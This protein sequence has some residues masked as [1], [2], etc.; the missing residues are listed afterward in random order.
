MT[1][2]R[3][4]HREAIDEDKAFIL[5]LLRTRLPHYNLHQK[6]LPSSNDAPQFR[7]LETEEMDILAVW[8]VEI[9][10]QKVGAWHMQFD[11]H[12]EFLRIFWLS[13][14][15][16]I[17]GVGSYIIKEVRR[18]S[19]AKG[20]HEAR[21][22]VNL[23]NSKAIRCYMNNGFEVDENYFKEIEMKMKI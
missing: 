17:K 19:K 12:G 5:E 3:Y 1:T 4:S 9:G 13:S 21:L 8:I 18:Y 11:N 7:Q 20:Y 6:R 23:K 22:S 10:E 16:N 15:E 14:I 2:N